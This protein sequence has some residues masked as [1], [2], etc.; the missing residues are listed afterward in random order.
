MSNRPRRCERRRAAMVVFLLL[1]LP[2]CENDS[3]SPTEPAGPKPGGTITGRY[4]LELAPAASCGGRT[5]SFTVEVTQTG[6]SPHPGAQLLLVSSDPA[7]LE[8]ELKYTDDTLEGG[9]GTTGSGQLAREGSL[10]YVNAI[11][12]GKTTQ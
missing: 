8:F 11:A 4:T 1:S 3:P 10:A 6:T 12:S 7:L 2:A 5:V 9:V